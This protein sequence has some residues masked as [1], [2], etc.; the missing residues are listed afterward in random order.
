QGGGGRTES[1]AVLQIEN[2]YA[3][4]GFGNRCEIIPSQ[5]G[6]HGQVGPDLPFILNVRH[7]EG[8]PE[9]VTIPGSRKVNGIDLIVDERRVVTHSAL[10]G[11][12]Q[13][14]RLTLVQLNSL[15]FNACL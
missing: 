15:Y 13:G 3:V 4:M 10:H 2:T 11:D 8:A 5:T 7:D 1:L 12:R 6:V 9:R 14:L